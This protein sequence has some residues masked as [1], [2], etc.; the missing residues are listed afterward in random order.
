MKFEKKELV[1]AKSKKIDDFLRRKKIL[2]NQK[3][4]LKWHYGKILKKNSSKIYKVHFMGFEKCKFDQ[5]V[6]QKDLKKRIQMK[7]INYN[8]NEAKKG[9]E[10]VHQLSGTE[11]MD[12]EE[13]P[14]DFFICLTD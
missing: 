12:T 2:K 7:K 3:K 9:F 6:N 10:F 13:V 8:S 11:Q 14:I 4:N 5:A 1:W